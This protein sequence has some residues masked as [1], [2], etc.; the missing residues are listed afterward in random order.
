MEADSDNDDKSSPQSHQ[1]QQ[2]SSQVPSSTSA[3]AT[4]LVE[5]V[6]TLVEVGLN[7]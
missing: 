6:I 4:P 5:N 3:Q 7:Q 1:E 2:S